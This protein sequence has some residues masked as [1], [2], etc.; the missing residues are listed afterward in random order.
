MTEEKKQLEKTK[1]ITGNVSRDELATRIEKALETAFDYSQFDGDHHKAWAI[2][3]MVRALTG[4]DYE[5]WVANFE[6]DEATQD[7]YE[8]GTGIAP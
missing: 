1:D 3:Q 6:L 5:K 2:D 7:E 8:W 4:E